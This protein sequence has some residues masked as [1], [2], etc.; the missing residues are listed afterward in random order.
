MLST[1][2]ARLRGFVRAGLALFAMGALAAPALAWDTNIAGPS[3]QNVVVGT[4]GA[5]VGV[6]WST[7]TGEVWP[8]GT[9]VVWSMINAS[10]AAVDTSYGAPC[11]NGTGDTEIEF[12]LRLHRL[13]LPGHLRDRQLPASRHAQ[14]AGRDARDLHRHR[15]S[16]VDLDQRRRPRRG[17]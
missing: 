17:Q 2:A 8:P 1:L 13:R 5:T 7:S 11:G 10:G 12:E 14:R 15:R 3:S 9:Q 16:A 6:T 4:V